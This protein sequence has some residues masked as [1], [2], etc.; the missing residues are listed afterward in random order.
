MKRTKTT[1]LEPPSPDTWCAYWH[2]KPYINDC[3][4]V[5]LLYEE[6]ISG[7]LAAL[8]WTHGGDL[9][10]HITTISGAIASIPWA[11]VKSWSPNYR[12][13]SAP[14]IKYKHNPS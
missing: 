10:I 12:L 13:P 8:R 9:M 4:I 14:P 11:H 3:A 5:V 2:L 1:E 6:P 7:T